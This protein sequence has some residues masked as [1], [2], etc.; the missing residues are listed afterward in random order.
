[1]KIRQWNFWVFLHWL[2]AILVIGLFFIG[3]L[4]LNNLI[5]SSQKTTPL[6]IHV[7]LGNI[8]LLVVILRL[9]YRKKI[10]TKPLFVKPPK[11]GRVNSLDAINAYTQPLLY[12]VTILMCIAG[13]SISLPA[14][15]FNILILQTSDPL[16]V[17]FNIFPARQ[18]HVFISILLT[19]FVIIHF[20]VFVQHQF[21][22]KEKYIKKMW[23]ITRREK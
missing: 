7:L 21:L 19:V 18:A 14:N 2:M 11:S 20:L 3:Q 23:F 10:T 13:I 1:M 22:K 17:D 5:P 12:F 16:P 6:T 8:L 15:L 9:I 4:R